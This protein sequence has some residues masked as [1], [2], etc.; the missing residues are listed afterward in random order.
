MGFK[1]G[2]EELWAVLMVE[3]WTV[4]VLIE[5]REYRLSPSVQTANERLYSR[6]LFGIIY[7]KSEKAG[8]S[9]ITMRRE[10]V[11]LNIPPGL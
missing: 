7:V 10:L 4:L 5:N 11:G 2:W 8:I 9:F 3:D 6:R 1:P